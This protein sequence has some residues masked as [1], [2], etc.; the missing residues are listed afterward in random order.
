MVP[1]AGTG[2]GDREGLLGIPVP[3]EDCSTPRFCSPSIKVPRICGHTLISP[4]PLWPLPCAHLVLYLPHD[5]QV[6]H[7]WLHH[8]H[9]SSF[10]YIPVLRDELRC[11]QCLG[12]EVT[13]GQAGWGW[14]SGH[15][16]PRG[17]PGLV[18]QAA[19]GSS[20]D[21][22]K[23]GSTELRPWEAETPGWAPALG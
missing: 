2:T 18:L 13:G 3:G 6:G 11:G 7:S 17:G 1:G 10:P 16:P 9:V 23:L 5:V 15:S 19:A 20:G 22:Q 21:L 12:G 4:S 14:R 8:E